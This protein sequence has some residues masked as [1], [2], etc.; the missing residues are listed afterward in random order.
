MQS[1]RAAMGFKMSW[2]CEA[3]LYVPCSIHEPSS[4]QILDA[5]LIHSQESEF[6]HLSVLS[7][8]LRHDISLQLHVRCLSYVFSLLWAPTRNSWWGSWWDQP[9]FSHYTGVAMW[10]WRCLESIQAFYKSKSTLLSFA[11]LLDN[12]E[13]WKLKLLV[14]IHCPPH[15]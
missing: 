6:S 9:F 1:H 2:A 4:H 5:V 14:S 12:F 8:S 7:L 10:D 13:S 15:H 3:A 11:S